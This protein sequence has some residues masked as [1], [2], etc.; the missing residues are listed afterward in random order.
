MVLNYNPVPFDSGVIPFLH[1]VRDK[2][3]QEQE[4]F[5]PSVYPA[6]HKTPF[7]RSRILGYIKMTISKKAQ[8]FSWGAGFTRALSPSHS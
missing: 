3:Q 7:F 8:F 2:F 6:L 5:N 4:K 1:L